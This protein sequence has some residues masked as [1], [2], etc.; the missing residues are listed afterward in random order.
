MNRMPYWVLVL[1]CLAVA[2]VL[3]LVFAAAG[4]LA[5]FGQP[6]D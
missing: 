4:P 6:F 1:V 2:V 5:L 3:L